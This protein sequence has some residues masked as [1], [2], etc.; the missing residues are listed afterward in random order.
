MS[1]CESRLKGGWD[2]DLEPK[3]APVLK[4][5]GASTLQ[6]GNSAENGASIDHMSSPVPS[7][8]FDGT[9]NGVVPAGACG[10]SNGAPALAQQWPSTRGVGRVIPMRC[11]G[12]NAE[13]GQKSTAE[14]LLFDGAEPRSEE[15]LLEGLQKRRTTLCQAVDEAFE[16]LL[17]DVKWHLHPQ[18][19]Q[20]RSG[21][22]R[23]QPPPPAP[24]PTLP[25]NAVLRAKLTAL[26]ETVAP[27]EV[28][29]TA[30]A[31][32]AREET[33]ADE[34][35]STPTRQPERPQ[36]THPSNLSITA[37]H[38]LGKQVLET[39]ADDWQRFTEKMQQQ[40]GY[41]GD[42][43]LTHCRRFFVWLHEFTEHRYFEL[44]FASLILIHTVAMSLETQYHS[45]DI[46]YDLNFPKCTR[47][48]AQIWPSGK[49][50][51]WYLE[52]VF[53]VVF[54]IEV[55]L[56]LI[57]SGY[58]FFCQTWNNIDLTIILG[59]LIVV[60]SDASLPLNPM[61]VRL[62]RVARLMRFVRLVKT[63]QMF[64]ILQLLVGSLRASASILFWSAVVLLLIIVCAALL[65]HN[66]VLSFVLDESLDMKTRHD[67]YKV[68]GS[69]ARSFMTMYQMT[70]SLDTEAWV[71]MF[72]LS[73]WFAI[74]LVIYQGLVCF[75]V[76][77]VIQAVF[78][79]ETIKLASTDDELMIMEKNRWQ[80]MHEEKV[81]ALF[82]EADAS[83]DGLIDYSEFMMIMH[84][85]RVTAWLDAMEVKVEDP[86]LVWDLLVS[87]SNV[88]GG[89]TNRLSSHWFVKGVGRLKG[90]AK[91]LDVLKMLQG[92][93]EL[94]AQVRDLGDV[95]CTLL[96]P[97]Q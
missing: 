19:P 24:P 31:S 72:E 76:I 46:C 51:M 92:L 77:N 13:N 96:P 94:H 23:G 25:A 36:W 54:T 64:D 35:P 34:E 28:D 74:P 41:P 5:T 56:K 71:V 86:K 88:H 9:S 53:G 16:S 39:S 59:W 48:A 63:V 82:A 2:I 78:L 18:R 14:S 62:A 20:P 43:G 12:L 30:A 45:W 3:P 4:A 95:V 33:E 22:P 81:Q 66:T 40:F 50:F 90:A 97:R 7:K 21:P 87:F 32:L 69:F 65:S 6:N 37:G 8:S 1:L 67:A 29:L 84:D 57:A 38:R 26:A 55:T 58:M 15:A 89:E 68:F 47:P 44:A 61:V 17:Q 75:A 49:N 70:F 91:S 42:A 80:A 60:M 27:A 52:L 73:E 79:N 10:D 85:E 83:G 11:N 93:A